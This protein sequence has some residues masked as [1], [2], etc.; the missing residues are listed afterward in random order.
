[1][2]HTLNI[3]F[4]TFGCK[5]N[6]GEDQYYLS[7]LIE[8][9]FKEASSIH[10]ADIVVINTCAVTETAAKKSAH[11]IEKLRKENKELKIIVTGCLTEEKGAS[12]KKYGADIIVTNG[13]KSELVNHIINLTDGYIK[14]SDG[15]FAGGALLSHTNT[16]T[17]AFFKIQDGCDAFCTYCIIPALRGRPKSMPKN[18]VVSGFKKLLS[19]DYKEIVLVGIHIGLYGR[20]LG[21]DITDILEELVKIEGDFRIRLT[22]IEINEINERLLYLIKNNEKICPHLHIPLQ[23]GCNR[24]LSFMGRKYKKDD[25]I[26]IIEKAREIIPDVTIG[27][28]IIAGFPE[29]TDDNFNETQKTLQAAGTEFYHAFPYSERKGTAAENMENKVDVK[30]R[31]ERAALLRQQ[32]LKSLMN[33]YSKS[34]GKIYRVLSEKGNKGHTENYMLIHYDKN[35]E[36]NQFVNVVAA[37]IKDGKL[38]G[39]IL[40]K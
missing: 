5:V 21:L 18:E 28:D 7:Q 35:I 34:I 16:K 8:Q 26:N 22:S 13:S 6:A 30:I 29:E 23:S 1:M 33:L 4:V 14:A 40:E 2:E 37:E 31:E 17:R 36:P 32:G 39:K 11:Y 15:S 9:G 24:I 3:Y 12:L 19:L 20:D 38:I 10:D 27:S 25:Y